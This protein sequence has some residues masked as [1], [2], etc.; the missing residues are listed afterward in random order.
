MY[1]IHIAN[2]G[3]NTEETNMAY[4][5]AERLIS[6]KEMMELTGKARVTVWK[7]VQDGR[8][9]QP[10]KVGTGERKRTL[11]WK[12]SDWNRFCDENIEC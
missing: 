8:L 9:P 7:M 6:I 10:V 12:L 11:G 5:T 4:Q 3:T 1:Y 2:R